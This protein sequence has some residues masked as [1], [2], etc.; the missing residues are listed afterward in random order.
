MWKE[1]WP[2]KAPSSMHSDITVL[3]A[4]KHV[5]LEFTDLQCINTE[6]CTYRVHIKFDI[7]HIKLQF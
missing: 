3:F 4:Y 2:E 6:I 5:L 7:K 1:L